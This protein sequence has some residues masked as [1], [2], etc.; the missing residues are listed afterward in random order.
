MRVR[1]IRTIS[2]KYKRI[3]RKYAHTCYFMRVRITDDAFTKH[4]LTFTR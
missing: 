1:A 2:R 4:T 3:S